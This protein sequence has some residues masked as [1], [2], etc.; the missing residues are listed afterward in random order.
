MIAPKNFNDYELKHPREILEN[1]GIEVI[2]AS[3]FVG[4]CRGMN[5][6]IIESK[7]NVEDIDP[8]LFDGIIIVG[9]R[10]AL[11]HLQNNKDLI[12]LLKKFNKKGKL[13]SA[14]GRGRHLLHNAGLFGDNFSWGP[15]LTSYS[16]SPARDF[17]CPV[18]QK[19]MQALILIYHLIFIFDNFC[20]C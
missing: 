3:T 15:A 9:G 18:E 14:I 11:T 7:I 10:G 6:S 20:N 12:D 13:V 17:E 16:W 8:D 1:N 5:R 4:K 2:I 19:F